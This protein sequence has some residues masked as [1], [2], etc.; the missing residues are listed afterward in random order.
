MIAPAFSMT[1]SIV[2]AA[3]SARDMDDPCIDADAGQPGQ[4]ILQ[5]IFEA[6]GCH[7]YNDDMF[8]HGLIASGA[9]ASVES[10]TD[11]RFAAMC[12]QIRDP[13]DRIV[14]GT[15]APAGRIGRAAANASVGP[16]GNRRRPEE[17]S[18]EEARVTA[19]RTGFDTSGKSGA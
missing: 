4:R 3:L 11:L 1:A 2:A 14:T 16:C 5:K 6:P 13:F 15:E 19:L 9:G 7:P 18:L 10:E 12:V 8:V 17:A